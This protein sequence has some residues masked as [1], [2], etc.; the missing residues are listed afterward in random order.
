MLEFRSINANDFEK[1]NKYRTLD[2]TNASEGAFVTMFIWNRYYNLEIAENGEY[3]FLRFN[4][5]NKAPSYFFPIGHGNLSKAIEELSL[6]SSSK[7]EQLAFRLVSGEHA[8]K[9]KQIDEKRFA[10]TE[11]RD[12]F[13]YVYPFPVKSFIQKE[14]ILTIS[15]KIIPMNMLK[16]QNLRC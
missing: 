14:I 13:D 15:L 3:L 6:Y 7:G 12:C 10:F 16:L 9:L 5:K 1:F 11:D 2:K 4:I 8:E